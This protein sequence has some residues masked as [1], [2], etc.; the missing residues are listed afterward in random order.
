MCIM[1]ADRSDRQII[2][3]TT[4][5]ICPTARPIISTHDDKD[6]RRQFSLRRSIIALSAC[7][8]SCLRFIRLLRLFFRTQSIVWFELKTAI[9]QE[10]WCHVSEPQF[11][12]DSRYAVEAQQLGI[13]QSNIATQGN[14]YTTAHVQFKLFRPRG[15]DRARSYN[16]PGP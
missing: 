13:Q 4:H 6:Q 1:H 2:C 9:T 15:Y 7:N 5:T 11:S 10:C 12:Y 3:V 8:F 16:D 14:M